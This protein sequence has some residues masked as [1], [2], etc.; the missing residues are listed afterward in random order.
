MLRPVP[1]YS[2]RDKWSLDGTPAESDAAKHIHTHMSEE[3]VHPFF[4]LE[5][6]LLESWQLKKGSDS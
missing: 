2:K 1:K 3:I 4:I 5:I 6:R